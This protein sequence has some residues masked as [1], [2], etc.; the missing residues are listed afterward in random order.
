M[1]K[2]CTFHRSIPTIAS[3]LSTPNNDLEKKWPI[4]H[5]LTWLKETLPVISNEMFLS[6]IGK[7]P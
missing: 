7:H 3:L 5:L 2:L 1:E 4:D 6:D